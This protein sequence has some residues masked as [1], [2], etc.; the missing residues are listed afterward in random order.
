[1]TSLVPESDKRTIGI[2]NTFTTGMA[3]LYLQIVYDS[4]RKTEISYDYDCSF[5]ALNGLE[6]HFR[7]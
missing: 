2:R 4:E 5:N 3:E 1:M 6:R 7:T